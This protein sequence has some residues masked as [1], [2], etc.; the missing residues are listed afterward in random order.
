MRLPS[1]ALLL[2]LLV[3]PLACGDDDGASDPDAAA[4]PPAPPAG[5]DGATPP[6]PPPPPGT[7]ASTPPAPPPAPPPPPGAVPGTVG[8]DRPARVVAPDGWAGDTPLPLVVLLHGFTA[9][10][11]LQDFYFGLSRRVTERGFVLLLPDG[12]VNSDG[13]RFWNATDACCDFERSGV[14]DVAYLLGLLDEL[15]A[16]VSIDATRVYFVGHSNGGFMAH[17]LACDAADRITAIVSLAGSTWADESR[18]TP[19]RPVSLLQ[20]HGTSDDTIPYAGTAF[21]YPGAVELVER[22]ARRD[23]C[24]LGAAEDGAPLDVDQ[25]VDGSETTVRSYRAGCAAGTEA[26]LWT[27]EGGSHIPDLDTSFAPLLLDWLLARGG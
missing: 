6:A 22:F 15:E 4:T 17:R 10:A 27:I 13:N 21:G 18:C 26:T 2:S 7:D 12:T 3:G 8:G 25:R 19:A 16:A 24:D 9:S 1:L 11:A 23:A 5:P 20:I 14:D